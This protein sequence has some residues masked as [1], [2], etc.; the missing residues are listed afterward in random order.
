[1]FLDTVRAAF[2][3]VVAQAH[4]KR[5][6]SPDERPARIQRDEAQRIEIKRVRDDNF[7]V[8]GAKKVWQQL[9]REVCRGWIDS[10]TASR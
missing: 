4:R 10:H 6:L 1:M 7:Q 2:Q 3:L 9:L 5:R 8:Y